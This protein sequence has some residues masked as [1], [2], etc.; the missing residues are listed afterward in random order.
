MNEI[1]NPFKV[2]QFVFCIS[3]NFPLFTTTGDKNKVSK[4]PNSHPKVGE[5]CCIDEIL[6]DFIRFEEYDCDDK[7][8][9]EYGY[10]WWHYSRFKAATEQELEAHFEDVAKVALQNLGFK[11]TPKPTTP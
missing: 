4:F 11:T 3:D 10:R 6:G 1:K 5:A 2:G 7:S 8:S 9:P